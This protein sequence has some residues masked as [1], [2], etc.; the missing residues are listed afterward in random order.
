MQQNLDGWEQRRFST[1]KREIRGG[2][3]VYVKN[4]L[5]GSV[6]KDE[7][8]IRERVRREVELLSQLSADS[9]PY[10]RLGL[11]E[12]LGADLDKGEVVTAEAPGEPL[13]ECYRKAWILP[14]K[15][16][17]SASM[18]AGKWLRCFHDAA[19]H[20]SLVNIASSDRVSVAD[21]CAVRIDDLNQHDFHWPKALNQGERV[22]ETLR[23]LEAQSER[24]KD[25]CICSHNDYAPY[26]VLWSGSILT[27]I[28]FTAWGA[29]HR[30]VDVT[31]YVH[32]LRMSAL[33]RPWLFPYIPQWRRAFIRGYGPNVVDDPMYRAN[34]LR[35]QLCSLTSLV[36]NSGDTLK[37]RMHDRWI[38]FALIRDLV[39][40]VGS[41]PS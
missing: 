20:G 25:P 12:V 26:N 1:V 37:S 4:Y 33:E 15:G 16:L 13:D 24:A 35:H 22:L 36:S 32:R 28:D 40:S 17:I 30:T 7:S 31:L 21:F 38:R 11:M 23:F 2:R 19:V 18:L 3:A 9:F 34:L 29:E 6:E 5:S 39:R 8:I 10:W 41:I 27:G 14:A